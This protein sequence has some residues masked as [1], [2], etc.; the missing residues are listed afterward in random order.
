MAVYTAPV[1]ETRFILDQVLNVGNYSNL[2]GFANAT[3]DLIEAILDEGGKFASEVLAPLNKVGDEQGCKR[4]DDGSVTVPDGFK[5]AYKQWCDGGWPTQ[6]RTLPSSL[7]PSWSPEP[8]SVTSGKVHSLPSRI[9]PSSGPP[10]TRPA[11]APSNQ[12]PHQRPRQGR[13]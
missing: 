6:P 2:Q 12:A 9:S 3:P 4:N 10:T 5:D 13:G 8:R 7:N 11:P 1:R